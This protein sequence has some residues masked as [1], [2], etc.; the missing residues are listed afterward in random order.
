MDILKGSYEKTTFKIILCILNI[1]LTVHVIAMRRQA[2]T[3]AQLAFDF[4][5]QL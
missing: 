5:S 2:L 4:M 3:S 1:N